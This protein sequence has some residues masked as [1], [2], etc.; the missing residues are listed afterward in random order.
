MNLNSIESVLFAIAMICFGILFTPL[1]E[2]M[3]WANYIMVAGAGILVGAGIYCREKRMSI[4]QNEIVATLKAMSNQQKELLS[5]VIN[6]NNINHTSLK[7]LADS[8]VNVNRSI[9]G[10]MKEI[11]VTLDG[12]INE[13]IKEIQVTVDRNHSKMYG[14][15]D[16]KSRDVLEEMKSLKVVIEKQLN[17][18][19]GTITKSNE[20]VSHDM[21]SIIK[22]GN[23]AAIDFHDSLLLESRKLTDSINDLESKSEQLIKHVIDEIENGHDTQ[24]DFYDKY[25]EY[26]QGLKQQYEDFNENIISYQINVKRASEDIREY[27]DNT[28]QDILERTETLKNLVAQLSEMVDQLADS[29]HYEREKALEVQQ[30]LATQFDRLKVRG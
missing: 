1:F 30:Q 8:V 14:L 25:T 27:R 13:S 9:N 17:D 23:N 21:V 28:E 22:Q 5:D 3:V 7:G 18:I 4:G 6:S 24:A 19:N 26:A 15:L 16:Q 2:S 11:Q 20:Q 12:I 10:G 29:K